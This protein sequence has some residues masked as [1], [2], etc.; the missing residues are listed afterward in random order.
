MEKVDVGML[1]LMMVLLL[2]LL[3]L[4]MVVVKSWRLQMIRHSRVM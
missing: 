1:Q 2:L 4:M 3:L